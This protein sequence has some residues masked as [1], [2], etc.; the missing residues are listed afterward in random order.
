MEPF[1]AACKPEQKNGK[2]K[3]F[4]SVIRQR[5]LALLFWKKI[6]TTMTTALTRRKKQRTTWT[7]PQ[8]TSF[9]EQVY[10]YKTISASWREPCGKKKKNAPNC[11]V[12]NQH[13]VYVLRCL[14]Y[15][16]APKSTN[17]FLG[18]QKRGRK[19][20]DGNREEKKKKKQATADTRRQRVK[21]DPLVFSCIFCFWQMKNVNCPVCICEFLHYSSAS[22]V[23]AA[24][25]PWQ[26]PAPCSQCVHAHIHTSLKMHIHTHQ[27]THTEKCTLAPFF[28]LCR[29]SGLDDWLTLWPLRPPCMCAEVCVCASLLA[30]VC[31]WFIDIRET[32]TAH[33]HA[34]C[35]SEGCE[36]LVAEHTH[37]HTSLLH[38][39]LMHHN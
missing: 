9:E 28:S 22:L 20:W 19:E 23:P 36:L 8:L 11:F 25:S 15:N 3:C 32:H 33:T 27:Y 12:T 37:T 31:I 5:R 29:C 1:T 2:L 14:K 16:C 18:S 39:N 26:L 4:S 30:N 7:L 10:C 38:F 13:T 35:L 24:P 34:C 6:T 21:Q 17:F